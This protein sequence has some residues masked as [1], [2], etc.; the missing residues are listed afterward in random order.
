MKSNF[1]SGVGV[2]VGV[3]VGIAVSVGMA[4]GGRVEVAASSALVIEA[5]DPACSSG[6]GDWPSHPDS[7]KVLA[8]TKIRMVF[9]IAYLSDDFAPKCVDVLYL[10]HANRSVVPVRQPWGSP[11]T[12]SETPTFGLIVTPKSPRAS[13]SEAFHAS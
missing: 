10:M 5:V 2:S 6:P 1:G 8:R 4:V 3:S 7:M 9:H 12:Y 11:V 13:V